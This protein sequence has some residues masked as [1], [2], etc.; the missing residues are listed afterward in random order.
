[1]GFLSQ[2]CQITVAI[3]VLFVWV[4]RFHNVLKEFKQFGLSDITRNLVGA[5]KIALS[6]LLIVGIWYTNLVLIPSILMGLFMI[7]AQY[8][9][10]KV[11]NSFIKHL[12][13]LFLLILS[14][15]IAYSA[16]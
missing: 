14:A 6:T 5:S 8:F 2:I 11:K 12:P 9:H 1:M 10:F 4:F 3:S 7:G 15:F 13:S 16:L